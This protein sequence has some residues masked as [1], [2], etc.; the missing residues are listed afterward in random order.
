MR[1]KLPSNTHP[2]NQPLGP[3]NL[4]QPAASFGAA[5]V[6]AVWIDSGITPGLVVVDSN[7]PAPMAAV[8][9]APRGLRQQFGAAR[10]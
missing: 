1:A 2:M 8:A 4:R 10:S 3:R 7:R 5:G 6:G 9:I